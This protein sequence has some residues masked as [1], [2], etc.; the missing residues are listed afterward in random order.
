MSPYKSLKNSVNFFERKPKNG[1]P[2]NPETWICCI[3][4][5]LLKQVIFLASFA[6]G[7]Q[8]L[9][10]SLRDIENTLL[11]PLRRKISLVSCFFSLYPLRAIRYFSI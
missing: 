9:I 3:F 4:I 11:L 8:I 1:A 7:F 6:D 5:G 10:F 2:H